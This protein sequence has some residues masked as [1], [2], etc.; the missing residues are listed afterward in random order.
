MKESTKTLTYAGAALA[1]LLAA[2]MS[3]PSTPVDYL[4]GIEGTALFPEFKDPT[5]AKSM[6]IVEY[7]ENTA[8]IRSFE[9]AQ[10]KG[11]WTIPSH[12]D[13]PADAAQQLAEAAGSLVDL[14]V[15]SVVS[16]DASMHETYGVV[17]PDVKKLSAGAEGVGK[18]VV[19]EDKSGKNL[20]QLIIGKDVRGQP[21]LRYV[22][23]PNQNPVYTVSL[24]TDKL[25]TRF[26]EWIEKDLLKLNAFDVKQVTIDDHSVDALNQALIPKSKMVLALEDSKWK[27]VQM[28]VYKDR[29]FQEVALAE[30]EELDEQKLNQIKN[31]LQDLKIVD[32]RH[33]PAGL[34]GDLKAGK[35]VLDNPQWQNALR[36]RGFWVARLGDDRFELFSN[37]GEVRCGMKD[38]VEYVLRFG[39][40]AGG[41]EEQSEP[42]EGHEHEEHPEEAEDAGTNRFILVTAQFNQD[43]I[44]KPELEPVPGEAAAPADAD[45]G[46]S[47]AGADG[48]ELDPGGGDGAAASGNQPADGDE[49]SSGEAASTGQGEPADA[50]QAVQPEDQQ[51]AAESKQPAKPATKAQRERIE[52]E[53]KRKQ[54]DY[55]DQVKKGQERVKELNERFA[56]WYYIISNDT[57]V[58]IHLSREDI[59]RKKPST[60]EA[61]DED[62]D[63]ADEDADDHTLDALRELPAEE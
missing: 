58:K 59:V 43:L 50:A 7:D 63:P 49:S 31:A 15:V 9:V 10:K 47:P 40:I 14:E 27:A 36:D 24:R 35:D 21:D 1:V 54:D 53:S 48:G 60:K 22:R 42:H 18:R 38:G 51:P 34:G 26:E 23:K 25:T 39:G 57:Y 52:K 55:N 32:V 28:E 41:G 16:E 62:A 30:D 46:T 29:A 3:R 20:A 61:G 33:K 44:A 8:E 6:E 56:D 2:W 12:E 4:K 19:L 37:Q 17:E 45:Q 5:T 13:Y 11:L